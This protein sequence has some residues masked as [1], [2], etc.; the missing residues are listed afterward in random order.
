M[1]E[2]SSEPSARE[3][4]LA[5]AGEAAVSG[6]S[7][8]WTPERKVKQ[9]EIMRRRNREPHFLKRKAHSFI[10]PDERSARS[11]RMK[12]LNQRIRDDHALRAKVIRGQKRARSD[13]AYRAMQALTMADL[14]ESRPDLKVRAKYHC[15]KINRNPETRRRQWATRR[16]K[17]KAG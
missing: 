4:V 12:R 7:A 9:A 16:A 6:T 11:G 17:K 2:R 3:A 14:M 8:S 1:V 10:S 15:K 13:P 5:Q